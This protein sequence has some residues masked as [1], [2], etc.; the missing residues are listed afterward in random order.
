MLSYLTRDKRVRLWAAALAL[1]LALGIGWIGNLQSTSTPNAN[2]QAPSVEYRVAGKQDGA[3]PSTQ[4][5]APGGMASS[6]VAGELKAKVGY[7]VKNDVS[8]PLRDIKPLPP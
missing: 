2:H 4:Q 6:G 1:L 5:S 7:S 8:P 3:Q